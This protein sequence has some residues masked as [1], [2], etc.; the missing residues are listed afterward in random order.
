METLVE[1]AHAQRRFG[2]VVAVNDLSLDLYRGE[3]LGLYGP[4][5]SGKTTT[6]R[7][8]LGVYVPTGGKVQILG[9]P[10]HQLGAR[11]REQI[12]YA[13]Q[14]FLYPPTL[15]VYETLSLALGLYG[16]LPL[17][18]GRA[19]RAT[20][21]RVD[22][23]SK[24]NYNVGKMSGGERRRVS[25]A[26]ALVHGPRLVFLDEPTSGLDP[27]LRST[28][29]D[30]FLDLRRQG[31]TLLVSGHYLVE[32]EQCDRVALLVGGKLA[33]LGTP[34]ELRRR[35]L[36]GEL[37]EIVVSGDLSHA[38]DA[39]RGYSPVHR[40]DVRNGDRLWVAVDRAGSELPGLV[41]RL[42]ATGVDVRSI[43][44]IRPPFDEVYETLVER[45]A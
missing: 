20:L 38:I 22:L 42:R 6:I 17:F 39:L 8:A 5:G 30:W 21:E 13:P 25:I 4:S 40:L 11:Q 43:N 36:G 16:K 23:W 9:V 10:S 1:C 41:D 24:R 3:I 12:G 37:V 29:W 45:V 2:N 44:P 18:S 15:S 19:I 35:A 33:A 7:L 28:M 27:S 31:I 32:A 26:A 34:D 14:Q